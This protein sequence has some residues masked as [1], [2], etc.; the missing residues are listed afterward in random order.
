LG[1]T[2]GRERPVFGL[3][4]LPERL[5]AE[6]LEAIADCYV[7]ALHRQQPMGPYFLGGYSLGGLIAHEMARQ[8]RAVGAQ[9]GLLAIIDTRWPGWRPS[10]LALLQTAA[11]W[12][13]NLPLWLYD[14]GRNFDGR[15]STPVASPSC[16][17]AMSSR[18]TACA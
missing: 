15:H 11:A 10:G 1:E 2:L 8:L 6:T 5:P 7:E 4:G 16:S 14:E 9:V 12:V 3:N 17:T 18:T 13:R